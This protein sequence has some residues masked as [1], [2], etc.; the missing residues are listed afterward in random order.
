MLEVLD[1]FLMCSVSVML[2]ILVLTMTLCIITGGILT[3]LEA[4]QK[5]REK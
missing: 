3:V 5:F 1:N 2:S 4:I